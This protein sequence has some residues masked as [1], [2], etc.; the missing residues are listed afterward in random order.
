MIEEGREEASEKKDVDQ[1]GRRRE[2]FRDNQLHDIM[3]FKNVG[4]ESTLISG[5]GLNDM[6]TD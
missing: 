5:P 2:K 6:E 1:R 4:G 3:I